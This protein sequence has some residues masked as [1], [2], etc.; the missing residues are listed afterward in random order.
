MLFVRSRPNYQGKQQGNLS[1]RCRYLVKIPLMV[2]VTVNARPRAMRKQGINR[3]IST[4]NLRILYEE[5]C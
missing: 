4:C 3:E 2:R 1:S 5:Y